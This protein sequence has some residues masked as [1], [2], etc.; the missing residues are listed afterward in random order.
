MFPRMSAGDD[1]RVLLTDGEWLNGVSALLTPAGLGGG[2]RPLLN[3]GRLPFACKIKNNSG[4]AVGR[5]GILGVSDVIIKKSDAE[6]TFWGP[7]LELVGVKPTAAHAGRTAH[8]LG[9]IDDGKIGLAIIPT[10]IQCQVDMVA[11]GDRFASVIDNDV[12]KL[13]SGASG[14]YP[15]IPAETGTGVKWAVVFLVGRGGTTNVIHGQAVGAMSGTGGHDLDHI[16]VMNGADP[17]EDVEDADEP[18][19]VLNPFGYTSDDN[20]LVRAEQADNGDWIVTDA[21]CPAGG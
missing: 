7:S 13:R 11:A 17:R 18:I 20:G 21:Q 4:A 16:Q 9:P 14:T 15:L 6:A 10:A 5:Y 3:V 12:A 19:S 8:C 2:Q 1:P